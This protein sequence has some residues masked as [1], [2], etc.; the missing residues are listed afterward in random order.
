MKILTSLLVLI[1]SLL[2]QS[3][4]AVEMI[5]DLPDTSGFSAVLSSFEQLDP[6]A[7]QARVERSEYLS[8]IWL[9]GFTIRDGQV[10][11]GLYQ[12][13][14]KA[15]A[16]RMRGQ[17]YELAK[18]ESPNILGQAIVDLSEAVRQ[19]PNDVKARVTLGLVQVQT[20]NQRDGINQLEKSLVVLG[21]PAGKPELNQEFSTDEVLTR[22]LR[23]TASFYLALGYRDIG[24]WDQFKTVVATS[25]ENRKTPLMAVFKGLSLAGSGQTAA[26]ISWAVRMPALEFPHQTALSSG[27]Y[28][29]PAD[30]ANRWIKSQALFAA[31]DLP[32][33]R[34][35]LGELKNEKRRRLPF[36]ARFW[37]D[38]GLICELQHDPAARGHYNRAALDSFLGFV[39]PSHNGT[40]SPLVLGFPSE[41]IPFFVTPAGGFEAGSP[42]AYIAYQINIMA[43]MPGEPVADEARVWALA[44]CQ[45]LLR[46]Q[47]QPDLVRAFRARVYMANGRADL[48]HPDLEF[49]RAGFVKRDLVDPGTSI[50][51]GQQE[52]LAGHSQRSRELFDEALSVL[53]DNALAYRELGIALGQAN[54]FELALKAMK[55]ALELEPESMAG[56]FNLGML[57]YRHGDFDE[58]LSHLEQAWALDPGNA[59]VQNML[60]TVAQAK[61]LSLQ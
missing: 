10:E 53:P 6:G 27:T 9:S 33:A 59:Q 26:A 11:R 38:A 21:P 7:R 25:W 36:S 29:R 32:G 40:L 52:L 23:E 45:T 55:K 2:S 44:M 20:G 47:I 35:V 8:Q 16:W 54:E 30:Y 56:W 22:Y 13:L 58:A 37:Q 41:D 42:F 14:A 48:A 5:A 60:Q 39:Y 4:L 1:F 49:A 18:G 61:R 31:G 34:H 57:V 12:A 28:A 3:A 19:N 50:L 15:C 17:T 43:E 46:R 24:A 51:L